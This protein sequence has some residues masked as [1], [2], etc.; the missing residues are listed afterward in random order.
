[1]PA[2]PPEHQPR[3]GPAVP[4]TWALIRGRKNQAK[5]AEHAGISSQSGLRS[6]LLP[7]LS[8]TRARQGAKGTEAAASLPRSPRSDQLPFPHPGIPRVPDFAIFPAQVWY[9][10]WRSPLI[11]AVAAAAAAHAAQGHGSPHAVAIPESLDQKEWEN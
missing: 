9:D 7:G 3:V 11:P 8:Y 6:V 10:S 4:S 2:L 5:A 1:M